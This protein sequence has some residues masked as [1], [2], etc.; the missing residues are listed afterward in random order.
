MGTLIRPHGGATL[1]P[2]IVDDADE[3]AR[4]AAESRNLVSIELSSAAA[5]N[6]VMLAGG[7]F[8]PLPGFMTKEDALSV[9][10]SMR[11]QAGLFWPT[12]VL[13]LV[14]DVHSIRPGDRIA[15]RD[16]NVEGAPVLAIQNVETIGTLAAEELEKLTRQIFGTTD[17]EHPGVATF[18]SQGSHVLAGPIRV[19]NYSYFATEFPD[20][21]RTAVDIRA[22]IAKRG[23]KRVVAFQTRNPMHRAHEELCHMAM[24]RLGADGLVIHMLLGKLKP[25]D[26]PAQVR[27][28]AIRKM[29]EVYFPPNSALVTGYGFDML[30]A[31]PRELSCMPFFARIWG[32]PI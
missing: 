7:Y 25:G 28:A 26:I 32:P 19:L 5:S 1:K 8:S 23:W 21:F 17:R 29:V 20:T 4:L 31:G 24:Q 10:T 12:P 14:E 13:N 6:A 11:T 16:P 2:L 9:G 27:D 30:Y 15:L 22:E 3:R 18:L